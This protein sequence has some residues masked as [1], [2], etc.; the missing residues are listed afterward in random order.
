MEKENLL[1]L[2]PIIM[3]FAVIVVAILCACDSSSE[4]NT[5]NTKIGKVADYAYIG[6]MH[7]L[8]MDNAKDN[9][10]CDSESISSMTQIEKIDYVLDF[11]TKYAYTIMQSNLAAEDVSAGMAYYRRSVL[12]LYRHIDRK[13]RANSTKLTEEQIQEIFNDTILHIDDVETLYQ[14]IDY[15]KEHKMLTTEAYDCL[16][17]LM[18]LTDESHFGLIS[19]DE[20]EI[21]VDRI[22]ENIDDAKYTVGNSTLNVVG[23]VLSV[24]DS[25]LE[26]WRENPDAQFDNTKLAPLVAADISGA[27]VGAVGNL[28][29]QALTTKTN[30]VNWKSLGYS[31]L[32]SGA[33]A[34]T[35]AVGKLA[36]FISR[37]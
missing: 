19:D 4:M 15:A 3:A 14:L 36:S 7:N 24:A 2:K 18:T 35:G 25:S 31:A 27:I 33:C 37:M 30:R 32:Y 1:S 28:F 17:K 26:W 11:N 34:S 21:E 29:L 22:I 13:T 5:G 8:L 9:F 20:L 6:E 23:P 10:S 12:P 16:Y